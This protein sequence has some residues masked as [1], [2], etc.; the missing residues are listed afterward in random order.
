MAYYPELKRNGFQANKRHD[1]MLYNSTY[2]WN[3]DLKNP[4]TKNKQT[5]P[6]ATF[7]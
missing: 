5:T 1:D 7:S 4:K 2:N 3:L 6:L